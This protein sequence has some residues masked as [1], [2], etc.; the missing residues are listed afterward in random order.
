V[1]RLLNVAMV[2]I[3]MAVLTVELIVPLTP[4]QLLYLFRIASPLN[5]DL[6][7]RLIQ[8]AQ[9]VRGKLHIRT[10]EIFFEPMQ[11]RSPGNR[12]HPRLLR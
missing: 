9:I 12:Y 11:F 10:A 7:G 4:H 2:Q 5:I 6:L 8:L 3:A 1:K